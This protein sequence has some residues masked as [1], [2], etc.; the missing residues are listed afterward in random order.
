MCTNG[1]ES[2]KFTLPSW[3]MMYDVCD[4]GQSTHSPCSAGASIH[5]L[6]KWLIRQEKLFV[7]ETHNFAPSN[8]W[9]TRAVIRRVSLLQL[10]CP[11][12]SLTLWRNWKFLL[13]SHRIACVARKCLVSVCV[14]IV[15]W[16]NCCCWPLHNRASL[17]SPVDCPTNWANHLRIIN[18]FTTSIVFA[19]LPSI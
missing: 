10:Q 1:S 16:P 2:E 11:S 5:S 3:C 14:P 9:H 19:S 7:C 13:N 12:C 17:S 15:T 18:Y 6:I 8:Q 4:C